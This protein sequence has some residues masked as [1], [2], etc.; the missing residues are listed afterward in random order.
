M[1]LLFPPLVESE[2]HFKNSEVCR[3]RLSEERKM[4]AQSQCSVFKLSLVFA[5]H[6]FS[7][8]ASKIKPIKRDVPF[9]PLSCICSFW[10]S[11]HLSDVLGWKCSMYYVLI[12]LMHH[13]SLWLTSFSTNVEAAVIVLTKWNAWLGNQAETYRLC[14]RTA[15][16]KERENLSQRKRGKKRFQK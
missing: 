15:T 7:C 1:G 10:L 4:R 5:F 2:G 16:G 9:F 12:R 14:P 8:A 11:K 3:L 6:C 13:S